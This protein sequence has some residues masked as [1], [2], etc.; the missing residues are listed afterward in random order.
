VLASGSNILNAL[1]FNQDPSVPQGADRTPSMANTRNEQN[2][3]AES[4]SESFTGGS[5]ATGPV[6]HYLLIRMSQD[7]RTF[8]AW[9]PRY[10]HVG[11]VWV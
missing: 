1:D 5:S 11:T 6:G 4:L 7:I 2:L 3:D 10:H 8:I 9:Q